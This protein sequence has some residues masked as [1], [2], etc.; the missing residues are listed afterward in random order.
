MIVCRT[1]RPAL[2]KSLPC[3]HF[4]LKHGVIGKGRGLCLDTSME[5]QSLSASRRPLLK[6]CADFEKRLLSFSNGAKL[7]ESS[8]S[9]LTA[10]PSSFAGEQLDR[11][12]N[13]NW[14]T[15][16]GKLLTQLMF[17]K[18]L[19]RI[20]CILCVSLIRDIS[21]LLSKPCQCQAK[22]NPTGLRYENHGTRKWVSV[23]ED[24]GAA[25]HNLTMYVLKIKKLMVFSILA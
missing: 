4:R 24:F 6:Y 7:L 5:G 22:G 2:T 17:V 14:G 18:A 9:S 10:S 3:F 23:L 16:L 20:L 19:I 25:G 21:S 15:V 12:V 1:G 11:Y 13:L 8:R